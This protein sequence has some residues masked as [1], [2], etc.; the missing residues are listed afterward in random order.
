MSK[1]LKRNTQ[2]RIKE[3]KSCLKVPSRNI[4]RLKHARQNIF[5]SLTNSINQNCPEF[6]VL[7][8]KETF[9]K[10]DRKMIDKIKYFEKQ[11]FNTIFYV[12]VF[13]TLYSM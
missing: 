9:E 7:N 6:V 1:N 10:L 11:G 3:A 12:L 13:C 8:K 2:K 5:K 4:K